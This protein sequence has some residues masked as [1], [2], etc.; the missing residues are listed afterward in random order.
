MQAEADFRASHSCFTHTII[1]IRESQNTKRTL[2]CD[3]SASRTSPMETHRKIHQ[4]IHGKEGRQQSL[5]LG[6]INYD[7]CLW[8]NIYYTVLRN[9]EVDLI[10]EIVE[11]SPR[12]TTK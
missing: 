11:R 5:L 4:D 6:Q 9:N 7:T 12:Y 10:V 3:Q 2:S 8:W 1:S